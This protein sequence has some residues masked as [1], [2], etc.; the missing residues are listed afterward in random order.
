VSGSKISLGFVSSSNHDEYSLRTFEIPACKGFFL[1]ERTDKHRELFEE[2]K[3]A[4]FFGSE[5]ECSDKI[6]FYLS[7]ERERDRVAQ[8]GYDR[9]VKSDYSLH[10]R[11][12]DAIAKL[13]G[14]R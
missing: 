6:R 11:L 5:D 4:E 3:E 13:E 12:R 10:R 7:H 8:A 9:C 14:L 2:G 1:G